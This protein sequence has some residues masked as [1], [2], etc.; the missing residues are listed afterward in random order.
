MGINKSYLKELAE[1]KRQSKPKYQVGT[2]T[3]K[4]ANEMT[5]QQYRNQ[6]NSETALLK[7]WYE[8]NREK[9]NTSVP[10]S[11]LRPDFSFVF[12]NVG[13]EKEMLGELPSQT[14]GIPYAYDSGATIFDDY[15]KRKFELPSKNNILFYT[16]P[17]KEDYLNILNFENPSRVMSHETSHYLNANN[18]EVFN[19]NV[20][21]AIEQGLINTDEFKNYYEESPRFVSSDDAEL[22]VEFI[23]GFSNKRKLDELLSDAY[24]I[25]QDMRRKGIYDYTK[26]EKL[27]PELLAKYQDKN[28]GIYDRFSKVFGETPKD[29]SITGINTYLPSKDTELYN[30]D[31]DFWD[32]KEKWLNETYY[33]NLKKR[34]LYDYYFEKSFDPV[35]RLNP[36][37]N[38]N[39]LSEDP[40]LEKGPL[41]PSTNWFQ[42]NFK[43]NM[44]AFKQSARS[45]N[46]VTPDQKMINFLNDIVKTDNNKYKGIAKKGANI[47]TEGYK[48]NSPDVNNPYNVIPSNQITMNDVDF[49]V[50]GIDDIG[51]QIMMQPGQDYTFP[52]NYVTEFPM[53]NMGNKRF[54]QVGFQKNLT[55]FGDYLQ[56]AFYPEGV[57]TEEEYQKWLNAKPIEEVKITAKASPYKYNP[58]KKSP[59]AKNYQTQDNLTTE[60]YKKSDID[61]SQTQEADKEKKRQEELKKFGE[62]VFGVKPSPIT[63]AVD[64][65]A[66]VGDVVTDV[67]QVGNFIPHPYAQGIG[68]AGNWL[69]AGIDAYQAGRNLYEEDYGNAAMNIGSAALPYYLSKQGYLRPMQQVNNYK[70]KY[71]ALGYLPGTSAATRK[72]ISPY[73]NA[74][75]RVFGSLIGETAYDAGL[76]NDNNYNTIPTSPRD[77]TSLNQVIIQPLKNR[78][79]VLK[80]GQKIMPL[81]FGS[82]QF[83]TGGTNKPIYT[84]DWSKVKN[85]NDS[86][87]LYNKTRDIENPNYY[88]QG[89]P[90]WYTHR[91]TR[92]EIERFM[93]RNN[94]DVD[95]TGRF[96]GNIQPVATGYFGEGIK[97]P[98]YKKPFQPY[99]YDPYKEFLGRLGD[100]KPI[101]IRPTDLGAE[102]EMPRTVNIPT[103]TLN[104]NLPRVK[105]SANYFESPEIV[106]HRTPEEG[107]YKEIRTPLKKTTSKP[108]PKEIKPVQG[109][110]TSNPKVVYQNYKLGGTVRQSKSQVK[111]TLKYSK[112]KPNKI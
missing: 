33:P 7:D 66:V 110:R 23:K 17:S 55:P 19:Y 10:S 89:F 79:P 14:K 72:A 8:K 51:N 42:E 28:S 80:Q 27:T 15:R 29:E 88:E 104:S 73:I 103:R 99:I 84:S 52:G 91:G 60:I 85:Y 6:L 107:F 78:Q 39:I 94:M 50:L 12:P 43:G 25:K 4:S 34:R 13:F 69:G 57:T 24:A 37:G 46:T 3:R 75:R 44:D 35:E 112:Q 47:S 82:Y 105:H 1:K 45:S 63:Q 109:K 48:R 59:L 67:M 20:S 61:L 31:K 53:K 49:P 18:P 41:L 71:R 21:K 111:Q 101:G 77:N 93:R 86:L 97:Y 96:P 5:G 11:Y 65:A 22:G 83:Q 87:N 26:G 74:N 40:S 76:I 64:A 2:E 38:L 30:K 16:D 36:D 56:K 100:V 108:E 102:S 95:Y 9:I 81:E 54:G 70:G 68:K 58:A 32:N 106:T 90:S 62:S 98:I 92:E